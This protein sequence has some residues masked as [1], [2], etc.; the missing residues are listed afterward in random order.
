MGRKKALLYFIWAFYQAQ[1]ENLLVNLAN[2][3]FIN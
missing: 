1:T 3:T 2:I